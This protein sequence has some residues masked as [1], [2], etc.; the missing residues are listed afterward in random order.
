METVFSAECSECGNDSWAVNRSD[1]VA[2]CHGCGHTRPFHGRRS[3]VRQ[4]NDMT[5]SQQRALDKIRAYLNRTPHLDDWETK[6]TSFGKLE[7]K[8]RADTGSLFTRSTYQFFISRR[9]KITVAMAGGVTTPDT[10]KA[11][12]ARMVGGHVQE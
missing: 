6:Q 10:H 4:H 2:K 5:D 1:S 3:A 9:G 7:L 11:H 12:V 8:V